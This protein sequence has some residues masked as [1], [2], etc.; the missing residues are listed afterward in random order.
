MNTSH[1]RF[2]IGG[3]L[4]EG[5]PMQKSF[6][7]VCTAAIRPLLGCFQQKRRP[8]LLSWQCQDRFQAAAA[9]RTRQSPR[10]AA[11]EMTPLC[12]AG[13]AQLLLLPGLFALLPAQAESRHPL[14]QTRLPGLS[15]SPLSLMRSSRLSHPPRQQMKVLSGKW[16]P[17]Q[18]Q[19]HSHSLLAGYWGH[20]CKG[21]SQRPL[22]W[23]PRPECS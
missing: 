11:A 3:Q 8:G 21:T 18:Q 14:S 16:S 5:F 1:Y 23:L 22:D 2:G 13:A 19:Q 4:L 10:Q 6:V 12:S 20:W 7:C 17:R 9:G 15:S